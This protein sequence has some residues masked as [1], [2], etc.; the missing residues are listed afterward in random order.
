MKKPVKPE[1]PIIKIFPRNA[2]KGSALENVHHRL[3]NKTT[4]SKLNSLLQ[5]NEVKAIVITPEYNLARQR[6][7]ERDLVFH[8]LMEKQHIKADLLM[9]LSLAIS[10]IIGEEGII[11]AFDRE[12][13]PD[14]THHFGIKEQRYNP[15]QQIFEELDGKSKHGKQNGRILRPG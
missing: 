5:D 6:D 8:V 3:S 4:L 13:T 2:E 7:T 14:L 11:L 12:H 9:N 1:F 10:D 15:I